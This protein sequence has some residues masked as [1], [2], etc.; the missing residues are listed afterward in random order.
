MR[1]KISGLERELRGLGVEIEQFEVDAKSSLI[2]RAVGELESSGDGG[3]LVIAIRRIGGKLVRKQ[4]VI[5]P[6]VDVLQ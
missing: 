3:F 2:G 5:Q 6:T 4:Q 1:T